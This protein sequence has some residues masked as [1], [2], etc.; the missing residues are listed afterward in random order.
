MTIFL[1]FSHDEI[2]NE[3]PYMMI[4]ETTSR[5]VW[6]TGK[7]RRLWSQTFTEK[8]RAA[9]RKLR[10]QA[11]LWALVRGVPKDGVSMTVKTY[12]LWHRFADFCA[13]L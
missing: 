12:N 5:S 10:Q 13:N 2:C 1:Y 3:I 7:R 8:E 6:N 11:N 4:A 9:C